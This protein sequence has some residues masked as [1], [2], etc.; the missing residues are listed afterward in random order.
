MRNIFFIHLFISLLCAVDGTIVFF[1]GTSIQGDIYTVDQSSVYII[2]VGLDFPEEIFM[3][4]IDTLK[5][6]DGKILVAGNEVLL[7]FKNGTFVS[8]VE[9]KQLR[10]KSRD[11]YVVEYVIV[12]NYSLN[13]YTGFP[14]I[15]ASSFEYYDKS[16]PVLGLSLG[17]PYGFFMGDFF[18]NAIVEIANYKFIQ[19]TGNQRKFGGL[20]FQIGLS[21]GIFIGDISISLT[22]ATG[23]FHEGTGFIAGGSIDIPV[24]N[25][26][27]D[28]YGHIPFV[29]AIEE[30]IEGLE[31]RITSRSNIVQK[32][33]SAYDAG[34]ATGWI[35]AGIS[36]GYEF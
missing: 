16:Y 20:A 30:Q 26:I 34:G 24:G 8:P 1:D 36:I 28:K 13:L 11:E 2:P 31:V 7:L 35:G 15:K 4:N 18:V 9:E 17:T 10:K 12:P 19:S 6:D 21:P 22:A 23:V 14:L 33:K 29:E 5:L 3:D 27:M 32:E 25:L